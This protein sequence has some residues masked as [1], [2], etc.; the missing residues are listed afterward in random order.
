MYA[1]LFSSL[2]DSTLWACENHILRVFLTMLLISDSEGYVEMPIPALAR[3]SLVTYDEC[4][5]AIE[6]LER[7]DP[8][9]RSKEE[10]G[11]RI[12]RIGED[13]PIWHI[14]NYLKYRGL[15]DED[16]RRAYNREKQRE[17]RRKRSVPA[18]TAVKPDVPQCAQGE[19]E[20]EGD[21][22]TSKYM[23]AV[24]EVQDE[25]SPARK[26]R[27]TPPFVAPTLDEVRT[28]ITEKHFHFDPETFHAHYEA[29]GWVQGQGKPVK[30]WHACCVTF[31]KNRKRF[32]DIDE[33]GDSTVQQS[34][35]FRG[36]KIEG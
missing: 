26:K 27:N 9:S 8:E 2:L 34:G 15:R 1:K 30:N 36:A 6:V 3:R 13:A 33:S 18:C 35:P 23:Y 29:N 14:V 24:T 31:E 10:D 7:E 25:T 4:K 21:L 22:D 32:G 5:Q 20:V 28:Y 11:R 12:I 19:G 16:D 17:Y